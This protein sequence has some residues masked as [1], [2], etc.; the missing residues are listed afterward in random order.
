MVVEFDEVIGL[1]GLMVGMGLVYVC[2]AV[3]RRTADG[4]IGFGGTLPR[5]GVEI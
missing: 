5:F 4:V 3:V 1:N 2:E